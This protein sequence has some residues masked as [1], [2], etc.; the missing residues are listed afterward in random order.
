MNTRTIPFFA[1]N[2]VGAREP[3]PMPVYPIGEPNGLR[4]EFRGATSGWCIEETWQGIRRSVYGRTFVDLPTTPRAI[5][6][7]G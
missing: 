5:A 4:A 1:V 3:M 7:R 2:S 6:V